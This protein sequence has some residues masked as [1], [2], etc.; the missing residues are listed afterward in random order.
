MSKMPTCLVELR[1][2]Y[3]LVMSLCADV[4]TGMRMETVMWRMPSSYHKRLMLPRYRYTL[5][6]ASFGLFA[7][8]PMQLHAC[9]SLPDLQ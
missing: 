3:Y 8:T 9:C 6:S 1:L 4:Q 5:S 7:A 2:L